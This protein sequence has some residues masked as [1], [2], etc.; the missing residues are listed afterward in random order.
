MLHPPKARRPAA[1][2]PLPAWQNMSNTVVMV[3]PGNPGIC[4]EVGEAE[5]SGESRRE[6]QFGSRSL[7]SPCSD[8]PSRGGGSREHCCPPRPAQVPAAPKYQNASGAPVTQTNGPCASPKSP[9]PR[10]PTPF[11]LNVGSSDSISGGQIAGVIVGSVCGIGK[12]GGRGRAAGSQPLAPQRWLPPLPPLMLGC[13]ARAV[14]PLAL[15]SF[16]QA[17]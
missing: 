5:G 7:G 12:W 4:G 10:P 9:V 2:G 13:K 17:H 1:A 3:Q 15:L 8:V 14:S 16:I 11:V 6:R